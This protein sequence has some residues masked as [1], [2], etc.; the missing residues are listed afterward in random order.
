MTLPG[1]P[2]ITPDPLPPILPPL[3]FEDW[4][5][6]ALHHAS[7][8]SLRFPAGREM[9]VRLVVG[10]DK[11]EDAAE[12]VR[13]H[14]VCAFVE[15][16]QRCGVGSKQPDPHGLGRKFFLPDDSFIEGTRKFRVRRRIRAA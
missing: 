16:R 9:E 13:M 3:P 5:R 8:A 6:A 1:S 14:D 10:G 2:P 4:V 12:V 7:P 11:G 15:D